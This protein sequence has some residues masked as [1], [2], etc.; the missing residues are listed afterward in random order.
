MRFFTRKCET[1]R[2]VAYSR[3]DMSWSYKPT[4][5]RVHHL[6]RIKEHCARTDR[7]GAAWRVSDGGTEP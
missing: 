1:R 7:A 4:D 3:A 5:N 2:F 6:I